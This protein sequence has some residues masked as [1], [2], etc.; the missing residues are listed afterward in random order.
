[1]IPRS[2]RFPRTM[3]DA[4]FYIITGILALIAA[5]PIAVLSMFI[6]S[7]MGD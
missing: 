2:P 3:S 6:Y 5:A 1:M 7:P 4:Q